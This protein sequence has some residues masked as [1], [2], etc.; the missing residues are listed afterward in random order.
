MQLHS[1]VFGKEPVQLNDLVMANYDGGLTEGL[2]LAGMLRPEPLLIA[3]GW[4]KER[5]G[6]MDILFIEY[7]ISSSSLKSISIWSSKLSTFIPGASRSPSSSSSS[8]LLLYVV[9]TKDQN[10]KFGRIYLQRHKGHQAEQTLI[11]R[12]RS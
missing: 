8:L 9:W 3:I 12:Y 5:C 4:K 1:I 11:T 2:I 10:S 7:S 6:V